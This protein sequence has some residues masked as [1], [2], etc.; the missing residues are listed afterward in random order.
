MV[1]ATC[2][3]CDKGA[4]NEVVK[5]QEVQSVLQQD[6]VSEEINLV[7]Q[8]L[9][10]ISKAGAAAYGLKETENAV[11]A[12]AAKVLLV[13]DG[14][15]QKARQEE[16]FDRIN[17]LMRSADKI[18]ASISIISS[19]HDGGKRLDGLGGIAAILRYRMNYS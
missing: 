12:G 16:K 14:L 15:I 4:M 10:E 19:E 17:R 9:S 1:L 18:G 3:S 7:E 8:L 13:T 2:S 6:R 11:S 5:R